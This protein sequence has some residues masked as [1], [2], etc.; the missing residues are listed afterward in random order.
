MSDT[1]DILKKII[2]RKFEEIDERQ[3]KVS[4]Q[5]LI[6]VAEKADQPRGFVAAIEA[7]IN[8]GKA[9]VI[10]EIKKASPS[11]GLLRKNFNPAEI[12]KSYEQHGAACLS[13]LTD[14]DF[15]QG[16]ELYLQEARQACSLPV[17]RKDF[18]VDPYQIFEARAISADAILL[19]VSAL[20]DDQL[21]SLSDLAMQLDMDVL[22]EVHNGEEL[23]RALLLN[24]P[25]IGINNRNLSTFETSLDTTLDLLARIP[26]NH[27]VI[28]ES[29]I[30]T[31]EHVALMRE[32]HV[33]GFLVGEAFMRAENPGEQLSKIFS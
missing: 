23:E 20:N 9:A 22:V 6:E 25:L 2:Q 28:T 13:V 12:A 8:S 4:L 30:H 26:E 14:H 33:N 16:H 27:T 11:K 7:K 17:I 1:P 31:A 3:A 18:I 29:G 10:A 15:F 24:L 19:I 21:L 32:H 5:Q